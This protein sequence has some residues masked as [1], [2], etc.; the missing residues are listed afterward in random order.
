MN[1]AVL[2]VA[3]WLSGSEAPPVTAR[4]S[5]DCIS[6]PYTAKQVMANAALVFVADVDAVELLTG[7]RRVAFEV[8][9]A[10]HGGPE[11]EGARKPRYAIRRP[12][13]RMRNAKLTRARLRKATAAKKR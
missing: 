3:A 11:G 13:A 7:R 12:S 6:L 2:L 10:K 8:L 9:E 5:V 4:V 1:P